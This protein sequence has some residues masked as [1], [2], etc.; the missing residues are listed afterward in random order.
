MQL[1]KED[2]AALTGSQQGE[3]LIR[4]EI[5]PPLEK[6]MLDEDVDVRFFATTAAKGWTDGV[7]ET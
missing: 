2:A 5:L 3:Q 4:E 1:E 7:M 6:L